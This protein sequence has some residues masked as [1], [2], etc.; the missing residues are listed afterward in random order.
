VHTVLVN[1][2]MVKSGNQLEGGRPAKAAKV[3]DET[4]ATCKVQLGPERGPR[5]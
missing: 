4:S 2:Q 3:V 1:G 5:A